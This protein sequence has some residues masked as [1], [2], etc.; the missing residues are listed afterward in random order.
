[1]GIQL[2]GMVH[3]KQLLQGLRRSQFVEAIA[4]DVPK[5]HFVV[6]VGE[7]EKKRY[8]VPI[9]YLKH[10]SFQYLLSLAE[11][12]FGFDHQMGGL[13]IP[14]KEVDFIRLTSQ[15]NRSRERM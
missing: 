15:L 6:Y 14:C 10:P 12:E 8:V 3:A 2:P 7:Y 1:M 11:E 4:S 13:T 5:G 9:S